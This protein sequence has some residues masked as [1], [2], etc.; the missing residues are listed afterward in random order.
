MF[1]K[2]TVRKRGDKAY[3]YLSLVE[4]VR[5][6]GKMT[7]NTLL[8]LGEVS[9]LR[10]TG[11]LDR[12]IAA[13]R[14][15]A[16]GAWVQAEELDAESAPGYGAMAAARAYFCRLGLDEFFEA[17]GK[18]ERL[19]D[20]VFVMTANRLLRPWSKRRT[21]LEWLAE[22]VSLHRRRHR[23]STAPLLSRARHRL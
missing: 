10:E 5:I 19:S 12:I 16:E 20:A 2:T 18:A 21:I 1:V 7:H 6:D 14:T 4:S 11:Q 22:D 3:T 9:E 23:T 8:R 15:H 13:L 17:A